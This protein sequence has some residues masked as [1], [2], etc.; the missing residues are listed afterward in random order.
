LQFLLAGR[1]ASSKPISIAF[2]K[3]DS[4]QFVD[5]A[6]LGQLVEQR[7]GRSEVSGIEAS[8]SSPRQSELIPAAR[9]RQPSQPGRPPRPSGATPRRCLEPQRARRARGETPSA[10]QQALLKAADLCVAAPERAAQRRL[11]DSGFTER[12]DYALEA[13]SDIPYRSWREYDPEDSLRF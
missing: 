11:V 2:N 9:C 12:Y 4:Q 13:L 8:T 6:F 5:L 3:F 1:D 10:K 7:P